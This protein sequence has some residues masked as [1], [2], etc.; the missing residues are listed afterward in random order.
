MN[1]RQTSDTVSHNSQAF[2]F[3]TAYRL[4]WLKQLWKP[5]YRFDYTNTSEA[6]LVFAGLG[7]LCSSTLGIRYDFADL[8]SIKLEY[9]RQRRLGQPRVNGFF[10]QINN[11]F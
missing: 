2:Y 9:R 10:F 3:Q 11:T 5:F 8:A 6:D 7:D 1:H 4:P